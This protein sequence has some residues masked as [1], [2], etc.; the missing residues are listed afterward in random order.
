ML[1]LITIII[2]VRNELMWQTEIDFSFFPSTRH[3]AYTHTQSTEYT[4]SDHCW[5]VATVANNFDGMQNELGLEEMKN[6]NEIEM[7]CCC[8]FRSQKINGK[9][10][11]TFFSATKILCSATSSCT[12]S[13]GVSCGAYKWLLH[14]DKQMGQWRFR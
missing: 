11:M 12:G 6:A 4:V 9:I 7:K 10:E 14:R 2:M 8:L 1:R 5:F 13:I 3:T